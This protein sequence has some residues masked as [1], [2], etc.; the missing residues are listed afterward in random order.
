MKRSLTALIA[1]SL[2]AFSFTVFAAGGAIEGVEK[3][4]IN[5]TVR[6][7]AFGGPP[8]SGGSTDDVFEAK[9]FDGKTA[10]G[11]LSRKKPG[12]S[13]DDVPYTFDVT[14]SAPISPRA[15]K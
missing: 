3:Q 1:G 5:V 4:P 15:G 10:A 6:N 13:F 11:R 12:A 7:K 14:F 9:A 8:V 2:L